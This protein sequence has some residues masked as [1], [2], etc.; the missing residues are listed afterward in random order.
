MLFNLYGAAHTLSTAS[1]IQC[2]PST[3]NNNQHVLICRTFVPFISITG[4]K[5]L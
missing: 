3:Y 2:L 5:E 4:N 1:R